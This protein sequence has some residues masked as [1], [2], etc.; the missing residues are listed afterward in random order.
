MH[1]RELLGGRFGAVATPDDHRGRA[2]LALGDPADL[3][4]VEPRRDPRRLAQVATVPNLVRV[5]CH[6]AGM[7]QLLAPMKGLILSGG[8]GTRLRPITHT[9]AKQLV[10]IANK[11]ILFYGLED[12]IA[13]GITDIGIVVGDTAAEIEA[14]V[15]DGS[16]F[17]ATITYIPQDAPLGLAHCVLIAR[18]FLGDDD[19]VVYLGDNMLQQG[20]EHFVSQFEAA[21]HRAPQLGDEHGDGA[22]AAQILLAHVDD[23]RQFGVAAVDDAGNVKYLVEKPADPPSDLALAGVYLFDPTIHEAVRSIKPSARGELEITDAIQWLIENDYRVL[24]EVLVGWWIDTGKKDPLL[25]CNRLIL[26]TITARNDGSVDAQSRVDGR[27]VIEAGAVLERSTVRGPA[28]IGANTRLVDTYVGPF[29]S[30]ANDC[31]II[32]AE[33]EHSVVLERS[34]IVGVHRIQDS[35]LGRD[36]E[37]LRS[38]LRPQASRLMLGDH[39]RIEL[40]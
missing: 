3:V 28:I 36:V 2:D 11:P 30:I 27:V 9:S 10:P 29:T 5:V 1:V 4:L 6:R 8:A 32:D 17:G 7:V 33:I 39:S 23:P 18:D 26:E 16:R 13:A 34:R 37:V 15:G 20:L 35:L 22:P 24:H 40:E 31:E 12:M 14:A 25:D 38:Q 21:R 19:F